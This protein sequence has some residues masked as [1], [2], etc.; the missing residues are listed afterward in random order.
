MNARPARQ[1]ALLA[2]PNFAGAV[3]VLRAFEASVTLAPASF[4]LMWPDYY[5]AAA[6]ALGPD[7]PVPLPPDF[8]LYAILEILADGVGENE[9]LLDRLA[10]LV[11]AGLVVDAVIAQ[12]EQQAETIWAM[13]ENV[14]EAIGPER[15]IVG[16]D[17]SIPLSTF[18]EFV[19]AARLALSKAV[20]GAR[21]YF[22][23]HAGDANLHLVMIGLPDDPHSP[24]QVENVVYGLVGR[25]NGSISAEHGIGLHK[26]NY[27]HQSR[28]A[29]EIA[30]MRLLKRALDPRGILNPGK[31]FHEDALK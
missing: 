1:V 10:A 8:P 21:S 23:G 15:P 13:R 30:L 27:L 4:E 18:D 2:L 12:S 24:E 14:I 17:V 28:S 11:E 25:F 6:I 22:Y 20:P 5:A 16:F 31:I 7:A 9:Q 26:R 19:D 3:S 29:E